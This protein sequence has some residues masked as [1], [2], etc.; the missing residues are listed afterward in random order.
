M[1]AIVLVAP[2]RLEMREAPTPNPPQGHVRIRTAA[3][4]VCATDLAMID[5]N[6]R[7]KPPAILGHEWAGT[8]DAVGPGVD[9][10]LVGQRCVAEN[11]LARGGEVGFEHPGGYGEFFVTEAANVQVL[12]AT[13]PLVAAALNEPLAVCVR[14]MRR[15][16]ETGEGDA[17]VL[18]DGPVGLLMLVLLKRAG[19]KKVVVAGGRKGRLRLARQLG[20]REAM[21]Y[22]QGG[23]TTR[24]G[25][26]FCTVV[27]ASGSAKGMHSAMNMVCRGGK[28]LVIGDYGQARADFPWNRLLHGE[29]QLIGSNASAGAWPEAVRLA[30][31]PGFPLGRLVSACLPAERFAEAID[32][33]RS[34]R[35]DV[36]KVVM[37]WPDG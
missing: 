4:G 11:V 36:V 20:A 2:G 25:Y 23:K 29:L 35:A 33:V 12:P 5:G 26:R 21:D 13:F 32:M 6:P 27:E 9:G 3:C 17:L 30:T 14:A 8:V 10:G 7:V 1:R 28:V 16:G 24:Y 22:H 18:G 19:V 34:R 15:L 37:Q 31:E